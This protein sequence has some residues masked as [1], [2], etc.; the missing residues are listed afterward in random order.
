MQKTPLL[1]FD[2]DDTLYNEHDYV[3]SG[4]LAVANFLQER[5]GLKANKIFEEMKEILR[6]S[7]RGLSFDTFLKN[8]QIY[9]KK[10]VKECLHIY[11]HHLPQIEIYPD[12]KRLIE[13]YKDQSLFI[14]T[15]GHKIVQENKIK[16]LNLNDKMEHCYLTNRYGNTNAKPSPYCFLLICKKKQLS[17]RDVVYIADNPYKDFVGLKTLGFQTI[18]ILRGHYKDI[19]LDKAH[20][21]DRTITTLD[22]LQDDYFAK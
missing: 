9:S 7:G 1:V 22:E 21:A 12:A 4:F 8:N 20:E 5:K 11:R 18:R 3:M 13:R 19:K 6:E 15:D 2:L 16:A 10:L 17:P 14:V